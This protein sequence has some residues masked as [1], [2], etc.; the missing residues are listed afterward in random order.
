MERSDEVREFLATLLATFGTDEMGSAFSGSIADEDGTLLI[1][2]DP[3]EWW[4]SRE[5]ISHAVLAQGE[6]LKGARVTV[7]HA[8]GW[9][10]GAVGWGAVK[11]DVGFAPD[12]VVSLRFTAT[13]THRPDGWRIV[14]G[15]VSVGAAN[16]EVVG[17]E[18]TV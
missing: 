11:L 1:G 17:R 5:A 8:E 9:V 10:E 13:V 12:A 4:D 18:L 14:Q 15:H 6:E 2:T 16:E 3:S 7:T